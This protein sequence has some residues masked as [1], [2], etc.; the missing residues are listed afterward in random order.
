MARKR[1]RKWMAATPTNKQKRKL[2]KLEAKLNQ[3]AK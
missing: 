1:Y 3:V 2:R